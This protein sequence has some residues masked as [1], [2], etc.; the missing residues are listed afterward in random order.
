MF[1]SEYILNIF[2]YQVIFLVTLKVCQK[3]N[4]QSI[5]F[6][7]TEKLKINTCTAI[8]IISSRGPTFYKTK[9]LMP[10]TKLHKM[11]KKNFQCEQMLLIIKVRRSGLG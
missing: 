3:G 9:S 2:E 11:N 7:S 10:P 8:P 1:L 6:R 5:K 4:Y